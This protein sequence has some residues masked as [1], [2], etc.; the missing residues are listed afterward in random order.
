MK[1]VRSKKKAADPKSAD[2]VSDDKKLPKIKVKKEGAPMPSPDFSNISG[3]SWKVLIVDDEPDVH[4]ITKLSLKKF[5]FADKNVEF[6]HAMSGEEARE[7]LKTHPDIA[8]ALVDVVMETEDAGLRLVSFIREEM[9][10]SA[11]RLIIRTGQPGAAPER[12]VIDHYDIDDYKDKTELI[13]QKLYTTI[14]S[15]IKAYRDISLIQRNREGLEKILNAS[16]ELY[17]IQSMENFFEGVLHQMIGC[18]NLGSHNLIST[19]NG[20]LAISDDGSSVSVR[21]G[22]GKFSGDSQTEESDTIIRDFLDSEKTVSE[23][24]ILI[25]LKVHEETIGMI[26][27]EDAHLAGEEDLHL[28]NIMANQCSAA[29]ANLKLYHDLEKSNEMNERKN[30]LLGMAAH[31]LRNPLGG[32][33]MALEMALMSF[34]DELESDIKELLNLAKSM[35]EFSLELV[36]DL[37]DVA[38]IESGKFELE[39]V[40]M[41]LSVLVS[42]CLEKSRF[43]SESK[44]IQILSDSESD[45]PDINIDPRKIQQVIVNLI[46]NAVKYSEPNTTVRVMISKHGDQVVLSV[47]DEGQGIPEDELKKLFQPFSRTSVRSTAGEEST[48]LGLMIC[49]KIVDAHGGRIS[50]ESET[51][52]GSTFSIY[53][54][55]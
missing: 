19:T 28:I 44:Y 34:G 37:L 4:A 22:T 48:G 17:R 18:C 38:K 5:K 14:R 2:P 10:N 41:N 24:S 35:S 52:K 7:I 8:A 9:Q 45:L 1:L 31:D 25:P 46:S 51:G 20:F 43:L 50:V 12:H 53:L 27:I 16:P 36:K 39:L 47:R 49:K 32:I 6:L 30:Q 55:V 3:A 29:M 13:A 11:I 33:D 42:E 40:R 15:A 23:K 21:S 54:P 26:Y